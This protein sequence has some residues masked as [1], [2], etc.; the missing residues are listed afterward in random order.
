MTTTIQWTD[1]T[2]NPVT[3]CTKIS[4]GCR[5]CYIERTPAFRM[6]GR[7]FVNGTTGIQ[8]HPDRLAQPLHWTKPRRV[9]VN[10]MSD[11]FHPAIDDEFICRVFGTMLAGKQ[12]QFQVLTKRPARM[13][14]LM[15]HVIFAKDVAVYGNWDDPIV[16]WPLPNVLLG[17]S[18]ENQETANERI[19]ILL[20]TPAAVRWISAEPLLGPVDL[21]R[22]LGPQRL[23]LGR[24]CTVDRGLDWVIAGGESGPRARP[25]DVAWI[26]SIL[27][28]CH[29]AGVP[30]FVKQVGSR[31]KFYPHCSMIALK[32]SKGGDMSEW[33]ADLRVREWPT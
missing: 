7:K 33:P 12:H 29:D 10:S 14:H 19:P 16:P 15:R 3:G 27:A 1:E 5:H 13:R 4:E 32:D 30:C 20:Q 31:P 24:P 23:T 28:Q 22:Y 9:F 2:W 11:L 17:T 6:H 21:S 18:V 8:L 25:C 26:R